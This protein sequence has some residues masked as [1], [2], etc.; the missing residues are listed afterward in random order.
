MAKNNNTLF[1]IAAIIAAVILSTPI[2]LTT[3]QKY[4]VDQLHTAYRKK[5]QHLIAKIEQM[6][7]SVIPTSGYRSFQEQANLWMENKKNA[8]PGLSHHNY[9][10]ALDINLQKGVELWRKSTAKEEW[11]KTGVPQLAKAL[12]FSWGGDYN[13]YHDPVHFYIPLDTKKL[14]STAY[15]QFGNDPSNVKGNEVKIV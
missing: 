11:M 3:A 7:Y 2:L 4:F 1:I 8:M 6:G 15:T 12:G 14:L 5:F 10:L 13:S 9:G